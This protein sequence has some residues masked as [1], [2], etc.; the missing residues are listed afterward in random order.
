MK[1][2]R[3]DFL[4]N[5]CVAALTAALVSPAAFGQSKS[6]K[7]LAGPLAANAKD[8]LARL[9]RMDF[10]P[11]I[12]E[13]MQTSDPSGHTAEFQLIEA[14]DLSLDKNLSRGYVGESY[15]LI[16]ERTAKLKSDGDLYQF[17]H[18]ALGRFSLLLVAVGRSGKRYEAVVN[19][20]ARTA[21]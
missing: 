19:R 9:T 12:G 11:Y 20:I 2:S 15:S 18:Y 14:N 13:V 3:R 16:F 17:D 10:V 21:G 4:H 8:P 5:T 6:S 1:T 7:P